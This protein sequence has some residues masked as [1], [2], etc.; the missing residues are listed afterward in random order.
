MDQPSLKNKLLIWF[1]AV[2]LLSINLWLGWQVYD[3]FRVRPTPTPASADVQPVFPTSGCDLECQAYVDSQ[4]A[5]A[6][7]TKLVKPS[8]T[9]TPTPARIAA[10]SVAGGPTPKPKV[11]SIS[12]LPISVSG[13]TASQDWAGL[14]GTEFYFD[15]A[16][17]PGLV[18]IYFEANIR[19]LNGNGIAYVRLFD[20]VHGIGVQGSEVNTTNQAS[21][22][23]ESGQVSFWSG[24]N[25]IRVQAKSLT[26][27]TAIFDGGRLR[28]ITEN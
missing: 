7:G 3:H 21:T 28:I 13:S 18:S 26:A 16:N 12:Y 20:T 14:G 10:P 23:V 17:Y 6:L 8:P 22:A 2:D 27:D 25:L 9:P 24:K 1:L 19:L 4:V 11:R 15:I 5:A